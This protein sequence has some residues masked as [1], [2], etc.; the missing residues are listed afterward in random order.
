MPTKFIKC[1][2]EDRVLREDGFYPILINGKNVGFNLDLRINYYRGL[3]VSSVEEIRLEIDGKEIPQDKIQVSVNGKLFAIRQLKELYAE[4]WG[5][6]T[7]IHLLIHN[8][9][10]EDGR[11]EVAVTVHHRSPYMKF[12][13]NEYGMI[14]GSAKKVMKLGEGR[15]LV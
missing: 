10:I 11:H 6:K 14:D 12:G 13:E 8:Y 15:E 7:P 4:Y 2:F 1:G 3:P 9:R 5:I